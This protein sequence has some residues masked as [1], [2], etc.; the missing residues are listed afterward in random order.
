M[1]N[2]LQLCIPIGLEACW[3]RLSIWPIRGTSTSLSRPYEIC[4]FWLHNP[5]FAEYVQLFAISARYTRMVEQDPISRICSFGPVLH[6]IAP[7]LKNLR[8]LMLDIIPELSM[9]FL[10]AL[11]SQPLFAYD[12]AMQ[13]PLFGCVG[14]GAQ[15][16]SQHHQPPR[17]ML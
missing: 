11:F 16:Q 14:P 8:L 5:K 4:T 10:G 17:T 15:T 6:T 13:C 12:L 7:L 2:V 9:E 1:S 3:V